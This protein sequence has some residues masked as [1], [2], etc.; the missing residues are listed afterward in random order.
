MSDYRD[1]N[2][3]VNLTYLSQELKPL[4]NMIRCIPLS[5]NKDVIIWGVTKDGNYIVASGYETMQNKET[6]PVWAKA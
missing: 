1:N 2:E 3:W 5:S 6:T 4:M